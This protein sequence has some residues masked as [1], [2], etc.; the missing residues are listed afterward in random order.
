MDR[1]DAA[2]QDAEVQDA[3]P[4]AAPA[5]PI[6]P[7]AKR[8]RA[9]FT[10]EQKE[11]ARRR[12][13]LVGREVERRSRPGQWVAPPIARGGTRVDRGVAAYDNGINVLGLRVRAYNTIAQQWNLGT[14]RSV[15]IRKPVGQGVNPSAGFFVI[16]VVEHD[17]TPL[18]DRAYE[19]SCLELIPN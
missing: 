1:S 6:P 11:A 13:N 9:P 16:A 7:S 14:I 15:H 17:E 3:V 18:T 19:V 5:V 10:D 2:S 4:A 8:P 12:S